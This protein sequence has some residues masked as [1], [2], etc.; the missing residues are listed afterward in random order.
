MKLAD[1]RILAFIEH[2]Y[3]HLAPPAP[4]DLCHGGHYTVGGDRFRRFQDGLETYGRRG[5]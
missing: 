5:A 3:I 4:E 2:R 1:L